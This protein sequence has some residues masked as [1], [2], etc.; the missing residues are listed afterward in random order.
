MRNWIF[1]IY[2][3][4]KLKPKRMTTFAFF[5]LI[6]FFSLALFRYNYRSS[7]TNKLISLGSNLRKLVY[8]VSSKSGLVFSLRLQPYN[9]NF[10][11]VFKEFFLFICLENAAVWPE[12]TPD[13]GRGAGPPLLCG[14][15]SEPPPRR[16]SL[17]LLHS[18]LVT[19]PLR[20]LR[21]LDEPEPRHLRQ[22]GQQF[23]HRR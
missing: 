6:L 5:L 10:Y 4:R 21:L 19:S 14:I 12:E 1:W 11:M 2:W 22:L 17:H 3:R 16:L 13:G 18:L 20:H 9:A 15:W 8:T 23:R 7:E